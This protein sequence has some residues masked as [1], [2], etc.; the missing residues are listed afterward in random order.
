M[1][2]PLPSGR[3]WLALLFLVFL[4]ARAQATITVTLSANL[5]SPQPLGTTITFTANVTD[6]AGGAHEHQFKVTPIGGTPSI[7]RDYSSVNN[8]QWTPSTNEG[9][10]TITVVARNVNTGATASA[11]VR[12]TETTRVLNGHAVVNPAVNPLVALFS[13]N[14]CLVPNFMRVSFKPIT[15]VPPGGITASMTTNLVPCRVDTTSGS[16]DRTSMNF[17]IAGMYPT[18][19]YNMHWETLD[20]SGNI[21]HVGTDLPFTT[22]PIPL[23]ITF[24]VITVPIPAVPPS[25]HTA[26]ILLQGYIISAVLTATDLSGNVLWYYSHKVG[27]LTRTEPGGRMFVINLPRPICTPP[28]VREIDLA[29]T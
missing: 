18:T 3:R 16:P 24:P 14:S 26:P 20:P 10:F 4:A 11:K 29:E 12:F 5:S 23:D 22:G 8:L 19:T 9:T 21:L 28:P 7:V 1:S 25:S 27:D 6:T 15:T 2:Y 13:T 17:Y